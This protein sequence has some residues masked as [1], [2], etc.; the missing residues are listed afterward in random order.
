MS[1]VV[2]LS[3]DTKLVALGYFYV[4][5]S[6]NYS[7]LGIYCSNHI[8][9]HSK[10]LFSRLIQKIIK[11]TRFKNKL[12]H[13][14]IR[15]TSLYVLM[16]KAAVKVLDLISMGKYLVT[17]IL[18]SGVS[19]ERYY[20]PIYFQTIRVNYSRHIFTTYIHDI[21]SRH[22]FTTY[23]HDISIYILWAVDLLLRISWHIRFKVSKYLINLC[24]TKMCT[25]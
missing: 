8:V 2:L 22:I 17:L 14:I 23:I 5:A 9:D 13:S 4:L 12:D 24:Q 21:Y 15:P 18:N 11:V 10:C 6:Q 1:L 7:Y 16:F 3:L 19:T 20:M 25:Y